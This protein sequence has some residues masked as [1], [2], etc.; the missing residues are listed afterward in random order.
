MH[1]NIF[2]FFRIVGI[3][4][5]VG[6]FV[7]KCFFRSIIKGHDLDW[8]LSQ[9]KKLAHFLIRRLRI[10]LTLTGRSPQ[11][12][13]I[14]VAN[15]RSYLDTVVFHQ[16]HIFLPVAKADVAQWSLIGYIS[17]ITG[18]LCGKRT[19]KQGRRQTREAIADTLHAG[20]SVFIYPE[21][22]THSSP[23]TIAFRKGTFIV[24]AEQGFP[25]IPVAIEYRDPLDAWVGNDSLIS[26]LFRLCMKPVIEVSVGL[27]RAIYSNDPD[28]LLHQT[29][30]WIDSKL[31]E[32]RTD[33]KLS[34]LY[35]ES[36]PSYSK[37]QA[38]W[39][40]EITIT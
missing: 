17:K 2:A 16:D 19:D 15:H 11:G 10:N 20:K 7:S 30:K 25:I 39:P 22:T 14:F 32:T 5:A 9:R 23:Q 6:I 18:V 36:L 35:P 4:A 3:F 24:A 8:A 38:S 31:K 28:R 33:R 21:G 40:S 13:V 37:D 1:K 27:G 12:P 26:H 34:L 29:Q